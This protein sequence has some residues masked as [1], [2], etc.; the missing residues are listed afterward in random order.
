MG[1]K[2]GELP[3]EARAPIRHAYD[4]VLTRLARLAAFGSCPL[5]TSWGEVDQRV[6]DLAIDDLIALAIHLRR[7]LDLTAMK[8]SASAITVLAGLESGPAQVPVTRI[9]NGL[10]HHNSLSIARRKA[11]MLPAPTK[12]DSSW[13]DWH[14]AFK[15]RIKPLVHLTSNEI[16][17]LAFGVEEFSETVAVK[18]IS[19]IVDYCGANDLYLE[20]LDID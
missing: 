10:I 18:V 19:A 6:E 12:V 3:Y 11:N 13:I 20:D 16:P 4:Q 14:E 8:Q 5:L 15:V 7:L 9:L 17:G 2:K 1:K